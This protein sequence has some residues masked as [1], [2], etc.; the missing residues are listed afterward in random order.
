MDKSILLLEDDE[1]LAEII[2]FNLQ[3][4]GYQIEHFSSGDKAW[5]RLKTRNFDL[6]ILDIMV[7]GLSG[8]D[9]CTRLREQDPKQAIMLLTALSSEYDR[10]NGL[11][12]GADDYLVKPFSVRELQARVKALL[13]RSHLDK[14][15]DIES[16]TLSH[17]PLSIDTEQHN[18]ILAGT[19]LDLTAKEF[20]LLYFLAKKPGTVYRR[21]QLLEHIWGYQFAGYEHTVNTHINRLRSKLKKAAP[22]QPDLVETVWGVGYKFVNNH[23]VNADQPVADSLC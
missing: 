16:T 18:A 3:A 7:P 17:G 9:I 8:L 1:N 22:S 4:S 6:V 19:E 11:E 14:L 13:R 23:R 5:Q 20:E 2:Q 12:S 21:E 15:P 10:V